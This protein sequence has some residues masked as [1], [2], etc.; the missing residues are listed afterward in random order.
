[1]PI[2]SGR[3][4]MG[5]A[6]VLSIT[7]V[8]P[9]DRHAFATRRTSTHR[10]CGL[11]GDSNHKSRVRSVI[12]VS[13]HARS[14]TVTSRVTIPNRERT[15]VSRWNVPPYTAALQT[16]SS[17]ASSSAIS[18]V[19]EAA[20]PEPKSSARSAPSAAA[21]FASADMTVGFS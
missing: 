19:D 14:S 8:T 13:G 2:S 7:L 4:L 11:F 3:W 6:K 20:I 18:S 17:P 5:L 15:S 10:R 1:M 21:I 12:T 16:T 9:R